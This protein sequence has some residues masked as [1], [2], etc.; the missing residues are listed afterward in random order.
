MSNSITKELSYYRGKVRA[1]RKTFDLEQEELLHN[2][3]YDEELEEYRVAETLAG[4]A[5][6]LADMMVVLSAAEC[7]GF[8]RMD[9]MTGVIKGAMMDGI[10]LKQAFDIVMVSNMSKL[11]TIKEV[12]DT[13]EKYKALNV[14][15][16]F[17]KVCD[18]LY[19]VYSAVTDNDQYPFGKLL[20]G[21]A[22][23]EPDW[24]DESQWR[25][26]G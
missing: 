12:K 22:Y 15:V 1:F 3:L 23:V 7:D 10:K 24:S 26:W 4:K 2:K 13:L 20:K 14:S 16:E 11:V 9:E 5:D 18:D 21:S 8:K 25:M 17:R 19:S 6:A